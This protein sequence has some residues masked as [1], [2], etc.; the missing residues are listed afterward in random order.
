M[1]SFQGFF[2]VLQVNTPE[3][4]QTLYKALQFFVPKCAE[5][6]RSDEERS[7]V[8]DCLD[9]FT[10]LL[11]EIKGEV[12]VGDGHREAIMNCVV[13]VLTMKVSKSFIKLPEEAL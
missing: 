13:D 7:V 6:I 3:S 9:A 11:H 2:V 8:M 5:L 10:K 12:F 1:F 4:K